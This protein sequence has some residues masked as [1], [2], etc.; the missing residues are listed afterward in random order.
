M[1]KIQGVFYNDVQR[2]LGRNKR[3][4]KNY[5]KHKNTGRPLMCVIAR[6]P[7]IEYLSDSRPVEGGYTDVICQGKYYALPEDLKWKDM[8]DK[9]QNAERIVARYR[10][11]CE[12]HVFL[13]ESFPNLNIDFGPG[14]LASYL[15]SDIGFKEDTVWFK[16]CLEDWEGVPEFHFDPENSWFKN[17]LNWQKNAGSW[18]EMISM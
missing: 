7:E 9:Y 2:K 18:P 6:K 4:F 16:P 1:R 17:I 3:K 13:A 11:F 8:E 15:G 14:S 12:K 5:W 10:D